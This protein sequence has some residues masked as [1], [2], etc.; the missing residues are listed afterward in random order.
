[1]TLFRESLLLVKNE[2]DIDVK[3]ILDICLT[4]DI[5]IHA[6]QSGVSS[7]IPLFTITI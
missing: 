5:G 7:I 1:M 3:Q 4:V 2:T 6:T